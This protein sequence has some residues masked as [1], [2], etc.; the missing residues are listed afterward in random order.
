MIEVLKTGF[1]TSIQ[2]RG[3]Y[4]HRHHGVPIS[5]VMDEISAN[6]A[7]AL[8]GN[9]I[10]DAVME[11]T[12]SGPELLFESDAI[13]TLCGAFMSP[14]INEKELLNDEVYHIKAGS[15]LKFGRPSRG[16]RCYLAV[17]GGFQTEFVLGSRSWYSSVTPVESLYVGMHLPLSK[18]SG[19]KKDSGSRV[20][21]GHNYNSNII[22][23]EKGP[24]FN[25]LSEHHKAQ[26]LNGIFNISKQNNRMAYQL[27]QQILKHSYSILTSSTLPGTVQL[28]PSGKLIILMKDAQ[29]TGG[30]PRILQL[31]DA[32]IALLSQKST[33][34]EVDF[35]LKQ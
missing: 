24:E 34:D 15:V 10:E 9:S 30:Y 28:T 1:L 14:T 4:N 16:I 33:S 22:E 23:V 29:T 3:R 8:L 25:L 18:K 6:M 11:I 19:L 32:S 13:I 5:G 12:L 35:V 17:S 2:D 20:N 21:S 31:T 26:L 7:N 27:K